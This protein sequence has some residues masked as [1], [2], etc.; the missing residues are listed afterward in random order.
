MRL[1]EERI[2]MIIGI[3][4]LFI[5]LT[6]GLIE[7]ANYKINQW[8]IK[9]LILQNEA[10]DKFANEIKYLI[11]ARFLSSIDLEEKLKPYFEQDYLFDKKYMDKDVL[12]FWEQFKNNEISTKEYINKSWPRVTKKYIEFSN[13]YGQKKEEINYLYKNQP[14]IWNLIKGICNFIRAIAMLGAAMLYILLYKSIG[15]RVKQ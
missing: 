6:T 8:D 10:N 3:L 7:V 5:I 11:E 4:G 15:Q 9:L 2:L 1:K 14:K 12:V 13:L